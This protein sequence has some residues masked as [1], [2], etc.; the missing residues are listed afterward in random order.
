MH[1][2]IVVPGLGNHID[3]HIK[4][5]TQW[6]KYGLTPHVFNAKWRIEEKGLKPKLEEALKLVDSLSKKGNKVS[7]MGNSAGSSFVLNVFSLRKSRIHK[8]IIN[9]GRVRT[10]DW[11]WF[12][13]TQA[14]ATSP[15]FREAVLEAERIGEKLI[16]E[17]RRK[18]LTIRPLFDE[19]VPTYTV[20]IRGAKN[21][22][23][24]I[25]E[26]AISITAVMIFP[27]RLIAFIEETN[28]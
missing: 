27:Q 5:T 6:E 11:P 2:I 16:K 14:T 13:F 10:G 4:L 8:V 19:L 18:I 9:C 3:N 21:I 22:T 26:H 17:D 23:I 25:I 15:S 12:T 28:R 1:H 24:P 7:L 20:P